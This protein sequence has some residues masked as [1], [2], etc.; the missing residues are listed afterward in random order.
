L[1]QTGDEISFQ[2]C[3]GFTLA[4]LSIRLDKLHLLS[5][6][7][8]GEVKNLVLPGRVSLPREN[9]KMVEVDPETPYAPVG[10]RNGVKYLKLGQWV[11]GSL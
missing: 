10:F 6:E 1:K 8:T 9:C 11:Y 4:R 7:T 3:H 2:E 5:G